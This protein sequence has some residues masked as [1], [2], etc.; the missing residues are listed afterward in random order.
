MSNA[1]A[2]NNFSFCSLFLFPLEFRSNRVR[3]DEWQRRMELKCALSAG[4][5]R[6][7]VSKIAVCVF[8]I[9]KRQRRQER[10]L[11]LWRLRLPAQFATYRIIQI[12][13][14]AWHSMY[15]I[16]ISSWCIPYTYYTPKLV[17]EMENLFRWWDGMSMRTPKEK[18]SIF[19]MSR[20]CLSPVTH[21]QF[22]T[23]R[24]RAIE[25]VQ[26]NDNNILFNINKWNDHVADI[27]AVSARARFT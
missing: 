22:W 3:A 1:P 23:P 18:R 12:T 9:L 10:K 17:F 19:W 21:S 8:V 16:A 24:R 15:A 4:V 20:G 27:K 25:A 13:L 2:W 11:N 6:A 26:S 14:A 5:C 7:V